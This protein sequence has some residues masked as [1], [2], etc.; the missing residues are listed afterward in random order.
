MIFFHAIYNCTPGLFIF[1]FVFF[2]SFVRLNIYIY[3]LVPVCFL[4]IISFLNSVQYLLCPLL[5]LIP[6]LLLLSCFFFLFPPFLSY[7][8]RRDNSAATEPMLSPACRPCLPL[9]VHSEQQLAA[10][11]W[12]NMEARLTRRFG[13]RSWR[14]KRLPWTSTKYIVFP[15]WIISFLVMRIKLLNWTIC[16]CAG[17]SIITYCCS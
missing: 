9:A 13:G 15:K 17:Q 12:M 8:A 7:L 14:R 2:F 4:L 16:L 10:R 1:S 11:G 6:I 5:P 3:F